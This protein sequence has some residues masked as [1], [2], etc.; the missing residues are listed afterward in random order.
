MLLEIIRQHDRNNFRLK[1]YSYKLVICRH[2][3]G[4]SVV[5]FS[6]RE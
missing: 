5:E 6:K 2:F 3:N 4:T 1:S